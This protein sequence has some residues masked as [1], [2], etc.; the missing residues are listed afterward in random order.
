MKLFDTN[1]DNNITSKITLS[2]KSHNVALT[3]KEKG[4]LNKLHPKNLQC[5]RI[6]KNSVEIRIPVATQKSEYIEI[7]KSSNPKI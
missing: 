7:P 1:T 4:F 2:Y 6:S 5:L 3:E